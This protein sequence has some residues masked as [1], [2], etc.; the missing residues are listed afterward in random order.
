MAH[1]ATNI[2][3]SQKYMLNFLGKML[4]EIGGTE[5]EFGAF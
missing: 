1:I 2:L 4:E 3:V 5:M